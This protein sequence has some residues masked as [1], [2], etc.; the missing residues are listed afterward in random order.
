VVVH[1]NHAVLKYLFSKKDTR[2]R[3]LR[4]ILL[5]QEFDCEIRDKKGSENLVAHHL[6]WLVTKN[7]SE[8][9]FS[10]CFP[11]EQLL[12]IQSEPWYADIVNCLVTGEIP[13][14]WNKHDKHKFFS[15]AR[16]FY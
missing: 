8:I 2:P 13:L 10:K 16:F 4:W 3:L 9:P 11:D 14:G 15:L 6:S 12:M 5:L 1:T 7:E